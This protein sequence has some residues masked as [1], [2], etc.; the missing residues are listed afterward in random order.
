MIWKNH[1]RG[2]KILKETKVLDA[3]C[4]TRFYRCVRKAAPISNHM[5]AYT[6]TA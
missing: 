1:Q 6:R 3:C 4:W 2:D 5:V